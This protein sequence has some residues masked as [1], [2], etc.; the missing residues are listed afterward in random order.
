MHNSVSG[1]WFLCGCEVEGL[2]TT[3]LAVSVSQVF[4]DQLRTCITL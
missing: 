3:A 2:G 4:G 1:F